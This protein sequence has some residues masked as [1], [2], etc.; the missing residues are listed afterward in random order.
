MTSYILMGVDK[1]RAIKQQWRI[2]EKTIWI[3]ALIG[4]AVGAFLGMK[5]F[6]HKTK[7][8]SFKIF[9]PIISISYILLT[10]F[11]LVSF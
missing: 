9:L 5:Q 8:I 10:I 4:G 6:R 7:H 1:Q 3:I 11:Y 2:S